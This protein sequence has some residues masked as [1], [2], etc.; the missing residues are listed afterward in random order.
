LQR[1][2]QHNSLHSSFF[3]TTIFIH[4]KIQLRIASALVYFTSESRG[5]GLGS[6]IQSTRSEG[7]LQV[8]KHSKEIQSMQSE[9]SGITATVQEIC[10]AILPNAPPILPRV[11]FFALQTVDDL[12]S[13]QSTTIPC[14]HHF[15]L[16]ARNSTAVMN[17]HHHTSIERPGIHKLSRVQA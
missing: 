10:N 11:P 3:P 5:A 14:Q 9:V 2:G 15:H 12:S 8:I 7:I 17:H 1:R 13:L 16:L 4:I 6:M